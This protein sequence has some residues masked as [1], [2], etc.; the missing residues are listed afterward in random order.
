MRFPYALHLRFSGA[1]FLRESLS[2]FRPSFACFSAVRREGGGSDFASRLSIRGG[3]CAEEVLEVFEPPDALLLD[4]D[5]A[6]A[7]AREIHRERGPVCKRVDDPQAFLHRDVVADQIITACVLDGCQM[8]RYRVRIERGEQFERFARI[9][10]EPPQPCG[11]VVRIAWR[12]ACPAGQFEI[13]V[14]K[15][16]VAGTGSPLLR[17]EGAVR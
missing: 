8:I 14:A 1:F 10:V 5:D 12:Q 16:P 7:L 17:E 6:G 13:E 3:A 11:G 4:A 15:I 2:A 9:G